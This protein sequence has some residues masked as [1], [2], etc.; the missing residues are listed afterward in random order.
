MAHTE[1]NLKLLYT[2]N[3]HIT[4]KL[5]FW[6]LIAK[7]SIVKKNVTKCSAGEQRVIM[8]PHSKLQTM[9]T[10]QTDQSNPEAQK[11]ANEI[12]KANNRP[13]KFLGP[14]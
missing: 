2:Y 7:H 11:P 13:I 5:Y 12:Q 9:V 8:V 14:V 6:F 3:Q 1:T 4:T 10:P